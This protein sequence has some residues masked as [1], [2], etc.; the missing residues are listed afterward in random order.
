MTRTKKT[1]VTIGIPAYNE[2]KNIRKLINLLLLQKRRGWTLEKIIVVNDHSSDNTARE[3]LNTKSKY[4]SLISNT[5]RR[6]K[7]ANI[8]KIFAKAT[9]DIV[10]ILDADII[11]KSK[12]LISKLIEGFKNEKILLV[13]GSAYP[14]PPTNTT[15]KILQ[16][17]IDIWNTARQNTPNSQMYFCEGQIRAFSKKLYKKIRFPNK[18]ADDVYPFLFL[19]DKEKFFYAKN[20]KSYYKNPTSIKEMFLQQKRYLQSKSIHAENFGKEVID[21]YFVI[22]TKEKLKAAF[23]IFKKKPFLTLTYIFL[24]VAFRIVFLVLP[25]DHSPTWKILSSTKSV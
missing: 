10:V 6:G 23:E 9:S 19:D 25:K 15:S 17:G 12:N 24:S 11:I 5:K 7:P 3:V 2:E 8:N 22:D 14:T 1:S 13:S 4:V 21:K 18:S 20:A 16:V